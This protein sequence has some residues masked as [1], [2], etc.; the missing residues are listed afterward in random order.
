[1]AI[2]PFAERIQID[3][4]DGVFTTKSIAIGDVSW[5]DGVQ[6][7]IHLMYQ[8]PLT[9]VPEL[10]A[11]HPA[12]VILH[13]EAEEIVTVM[14]YLREHGIGIGLALLQ[15]TSVTSV[16]EM[17]R[18]SDH[19]LIFSG[20]LGSFGGKADLSLLGKVP[21]IRSINQHIEIGW[22]G[23]ANLDNVA[24]LSRGG[25]DVLNVGSAIQKANHPENAYRALVRAV[26]DL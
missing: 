24:A 21:Q 8:K 1:M 3:L 5:P 19:V 6:A 16:S 14:K 7:D 13:A 25:I 4:G 11:L 15:Q 10:I 17:I 18:L 2:E 22:D 9:V 20:S 12:M 23:G 26:A